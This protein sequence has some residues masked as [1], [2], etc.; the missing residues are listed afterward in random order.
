MGHAHDPEEDQQRTAGDE[1]PGAGPGAAPGRPDPPALLPALRHLD[2]KVSEA[3]RRF[4]LIHD[5][6]RILVAASGG[7]DSWC[8]LEVLAARRRWARE[9]YELL[10]GHVAHPS[11]TSPALERALRDRCRALGVP[12]LVVGSQ[13]RR[14]EH[15][16]EH[17]HEHGHEHEPRRTSKPTSACFHCAWDRRRLLFQTAAAQG[18]NLVALGHHLDDLAETVLLNLFFRGELSTMYPRQT[19]FDGAITIVRP[20]AL[21]E[22]KALVRVAGLIR[23]DLPGCLCA[24]AAS[25]QRRRMKELIRDL[26]RTCP[27]LRQNLLRPVLAGWDAAGGGHAPRGHRTR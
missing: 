2:R 1:D 27:G 21:V 16:H 10:A 19:M 3:V 25:S 22:E 4:D 26:R 15:E 7:K 14:A 9:K 5:G 13:E 23:P 8:L 20:L 24:D 11:C 6:D 18:C 12:L 17:G